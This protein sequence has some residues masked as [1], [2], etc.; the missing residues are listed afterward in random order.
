[1]NK[2]QREL[3]G[4][5]GRVREAKTMLERTLDELNTEHKRQLA[6]MREEFDS[7]IEAIRADKVLICY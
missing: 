6:T 7:K 5:L 4:E 2:L 3:E 1:M